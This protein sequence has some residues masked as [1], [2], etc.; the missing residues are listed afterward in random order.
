MNPVTCGYCGLPFKVRRVEPQREYYCCTGCAMLARVP[1]DQNG[2]FPVTAQ[3]ISMLAVGFL[4]F[5]QLLFW[6][7]G[8][9]LGRDLAQLDTVTRFGW[10]ASAAALTVWLTVVAIQWRERTARRADWV[11]AAAVLA[12]HI[13]AW[14]ERPPVAWM[15]AAANGAWLIYQA[16]GLLKRKR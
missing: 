12:V 6:L 9:L 4:Y 14:R 8:V 3:L 10:L 13:A 11:V 2:Q 15:M 5:N 1:V 16:R 7:L